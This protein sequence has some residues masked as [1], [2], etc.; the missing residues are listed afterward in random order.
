MVVVAG[1]NLSSVYIVSDEFLKDVGNGGVVDD[2]VY[3]GDDVNG[4]ESLCE[5]YCYECCTLGW[6]FLVEAVY[7]W[8]YD[9]VEGSGGRV[10]GLETVLM[11][12]LW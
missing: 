6:S 2:F 7:D 11:S 8:V 5:V 3:E 10:F 4:V 9:G 1:V 12:T